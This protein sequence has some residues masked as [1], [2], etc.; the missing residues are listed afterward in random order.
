[1]NTQS[2]FNDWYKTEGVRTPAPKGE[3]WHEFYQKIAFSG[4]ATWATKCFLPKYEKEIKRQEKEI[5]KLKRI[6]ESLLKNK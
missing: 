4:G 3:H 1:M 5:K 2:G 6:M